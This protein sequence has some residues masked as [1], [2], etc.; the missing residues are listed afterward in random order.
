MG[1][2]VFIIAGMIRQRE[3]HSGLGGLLVEAYDADLLFDDKLG[4]SVTTV[5]GTFRIIYQESD[6]RDL[7][8]RRPDIYLVVRDKEGNKIY[9]T[10]QQIRFNATREEFFVI[11]LSRKNYGDL[12]ANIDVI[13]GL[14]VDADAFKNV[15]PSDLIALARGYRGQPIDTNK[16]SLFQSINST[17]V[18]HLLT[19]QGNDEESTCLTPQILF[20]ESALKRL[21]AEQSFFDE[22]DIVLFDLPLEADS[23]QTAHFQIHYRIWDGNEDQWS[24][25][26]DTILG[27]DAPS[28]E[29][30]LY[31]DA[32]TL[33]GATE[34]NNGIPN[35]IQKLAI[36]LEY[37]FERYTQ[38]Y[39]LRDPRVGGARIYVAVEYLE[40]AVLGYGGNGY[41][42]VKNSFE[43]SELAGTPAHEL[44]HCVQTQYLSSSDSPSP[45][46]A[47]K[48]FMLEGMNRCMEDTINDG[49][50]RWMG[51]AN[52]HFQNNWRYDVGL[53]DMRYSAALFWKYMAEQHSELISSAHEPAIGIDVLRKACEM[54]ETIGAADINVPIT[55]R[56]Q[57]QTPY[58]GTFQHFIYLPPRHSELS[59]NETTYG[60]W[61]AAN[62]LQC[63]RESSAD[64]R[65]TY[66]EASERIHSGGGLQCIYP[67]NRD[68]LDLNGA[69][70]IENGL[71]SWSAG[72]H[73]VNIQPGVTTAR[74]S[75]TAQ[76]DFHNP[77]VQ[78]LLISQDNTLSDLIRFDGDFTKTINTS[79][80]DK[81]TIVVG[82]RG[83]AGD[84]SVRAES[85]VS[86]SDVMITRWNSVAGK[87]HEFDPIGWSWH[88]ISPDIWVDNYDG[89]LHLAEKSLLQFEWH[90]PLGGSN[91]LYIRLRNKGTQRAENVSLRFYYQDASAGLRDNNWQPMLS[92]EAG[93]LA[94]LSG[95]NLDP[96]EE[97]S[98]FANWWLPTPDVSDSG[99][100]FH[101]CVKVVIES[102]FDE[103]IDNKM[104]FSNFC[105]VKES[106]PEVPS[107]ELKTI[108]V[109]VW[110]DWLY[111]DQLTPYVPEEWLIWRDR[112]GMSRTVN[113]YFIPRNNPQLLFH[114]R[115][116]LS[117]KHIVVQD[118]LG[119]STITYDGNLQLTNA[120]SQ[121]SKDA[122]SKM[123]DSENRVYH[124]RFSLEDADKELPDSLRRYQSIAN[125]LPPGAALTD[126]QNSPDPNT[127]PPGM[128]NIPMA[129]MVQEIG[130]EII[131]GITF[132]I[133]PSD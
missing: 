78:I 92:D 81:I 107:Y 114:Q 133:I 33:I 93:T 113:T 91:H 39:L 84:Y 69:I 42:A 45:L 117:L 103:N 29:V 119:D 74:I 8:E 21:Q 6:F 127:L 47:W 89:E 18:N 96:G 76:S 12:P 105:F 48:P 90:N 64:R 130:G 108:D 101:Y 102:P 11:E 112:L 62:Y 129:T 72:Y 79:E 4:S 132:V 54:A 35:Y 65:F 60:N 53:P 116:Y 63:L 97:I 87:E 40:G 106:L 59:T 16:L 71:V 9:S 23:Y 120:K 95:L 131:G 25:S 28:E 2:D 50:N 31:N 125:A 10:Q 43:D 80:L 56:S 61:L 36:W 27:L 13:G 94:L 7:F 20:I 111:T 58:Y 15:V 49:L 86:A 73:E 75:F 34:A 52:H 57:F 22:L 128:A 67:T 99:S 37:A 41:I 124:L 19:G 126:I 5:D 77:L 30:R 38:N 44:F 109:R 115:D 17:L 123:P 3:D 32:E 55:L 122:P 51:D 104:A 85:I 66:M 70:N 24:P 83:T 118:I 98:P 121:R 1:N 88:W 68:D 14:Q 110:A 82:A 100:C 46:A 26:S